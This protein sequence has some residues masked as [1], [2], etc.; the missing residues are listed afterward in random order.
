MDLS[1]LSERLSGLFQEGDSRMA[2][3][4]G[5]D[6]LGEA[7]GICVERHDPDLV[8]QQ[9]GFGLDDLPLRSEELRM[10][11]IP[12]A[13]TYRPLPF[14]GEGPHP[15]PCGFMLCDLYSIG[16]EELISDSPARC[17][18]TASLQ[19]GVRGPGVEFFYADRTEGNC[20]RTEWDLDVPIYRDTM[21]PAVP[22]STLQALFEFGLSRGAGVA[23]STL[24][25]ERPLAKAV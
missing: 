25:P 6:V 11:S 23:A 21:S 14:L 19:G 13:S 20:V 12:D 16:E 1:R 18:G 15:P 5:Y 10:V 9:G 2:R 7:F 8:P 4:W 3:V 22:R 24:P 17:S